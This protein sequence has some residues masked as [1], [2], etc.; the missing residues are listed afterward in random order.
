MGGRTVRIYM[1]DGS[2]FGICQAEIFNRTI[3]ALG[4]SRARIGELTED[5]WNEAR[6]AGV[7]FLFGKAAAGKPKAYIGEAQNVI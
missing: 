7:Y 4:V 5:E 3:Q 1:A 2:P 6:G